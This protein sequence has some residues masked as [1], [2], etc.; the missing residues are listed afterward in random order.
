MHSPI[1]VWK[2]L[3]CQRFVSSSIIDTSHLGCLVYFI[4]GGHG[5]SLQDRWD[6]TAG[7]SAPSH[8]KLW[9]LWVGHKGHVKLGRSCFRAHSAHDFLLQPYC[10]VM[11]YI[12]P[13]SWLKLE[14]KICTSVGGCF[15][16]F[17]TKPKH[18]A[19]LEAELSAL[20]PLHGVVGGRCDHFRADCPAL[21]E[22]AMFGDCDPHGCGA[23]EIGEGTTKIHFESL[24]LS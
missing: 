8:H 15:V 16:D 3:Q 9:L 23:R 18:G 24:E 22:G 12:P 11:Y 14:A 6:R 20:W 21:T 5:C 17:S 1:S 7:L 4:C 10:I 19:H 2:S 13:C